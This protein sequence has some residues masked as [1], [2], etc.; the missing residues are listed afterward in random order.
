MFGSWSS[1]GIVGSSLEVS[2]DG[3]SAAPTR[4][5]SPT[6]R[7]PWRSPRPAASGAQRSTRRARTPSTGAGCWPR[8]AARAGGPARAS[9]C[10][11]DGPTSLPRIPARSATPPAASE[12][13]DARHETTI[14]K[15]PLADWDVRWDETG[16]RLAVWI[17]DPSDPTV[18]KL[19]LYVVDPF[20]GSIDLA[21]PPLHDKPALAGF[22]IDDGRLAWATPNDGTQRGRARAGPGLDGQGV[23][24][25]RDRPR[26]FPARP[27]RARLSRLDDAG[28]VGPLRCSLT[29]LRACSL[30]CSGPPC[31]PRPA[32]TNAIPVA[33]AA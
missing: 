26:R 8:T 25:G 31:Q 33:T 9:S 19:S 11:A 23:W 18:G 5:S 2:S 22:S 10:W 3:S 4:S 29:G 28:R 12:Q 14:A 13:G 24:S 32:A 20:D 27:L 7:S 15:G 30:R 16:T 1:D 17:A 6:R 21:N